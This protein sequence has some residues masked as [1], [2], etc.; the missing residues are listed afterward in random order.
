MD[1]RDYF[2]MIITESASPS[3]E[4]KTTSRKHAFSQAQGAIGETAKKPEFKDLRKPGVLRKVNSSNWKPFFDGETNYA[5]LAYVHFQKID[6]KVF[7]A[8]E[9]EDHSPEVKQKVKSAMRSIMNQSKSKVPSGFSLSME[10]KDDSVI[11]VL[12]SH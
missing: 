8:G 4:D 1:F 9:K 5:N 2:Q 6:G 11:I 7:K 3:N 10:V 12:K